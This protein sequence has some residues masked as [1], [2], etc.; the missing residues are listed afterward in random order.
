MFLSPI[1]IFVWNGTLIKFCFLFVTSLD[2]FLCFFFSGFFFMIFNIHLLNV[3]AVFS[4]LFEKTNFAWRFRPDISENVYRFYLKLTRFPKSTSNS[5]G[6]CLMLEL[7][8]KLVS[9][10]EIRFFASHYENT[11]IQ[12]FE[13]FTTK[14]G[15]FSDK[16]FWYFS[17][18]CSKHKLRVLVRTVMF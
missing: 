12:Y 4:T 13:N 7:I 3:F 1:C 10:N 9:T 14:K 17:Y 15:K 8:F 16:K 11:L 2:F 5:F 6:A 18:F